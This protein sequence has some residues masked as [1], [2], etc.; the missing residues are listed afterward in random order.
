MAEEESEQP[1]EEIQLVVFKLGEEEYG[2]EI[3]D[4][5][6]IIKTGEITPVP[7]APVFVEGIINLRGKIVVV[8]DLL[9]R[10]G[11]FDETK[12]K[13]TH[14]IISEVEDSSFGILVDDVSEVLRIA[15]EDIKKAPGII[16]SK[17]HADYLRGVGVVGE[18]LL[19]LLDLMKVLSE[20]ELVEMADLTKGM[21][22]KGE[23][24][25]KE[26]EE[27]K[28]TISDEEIKRRF[29]EKFK[30][31]EKAPAE[32]EKPKKARAKK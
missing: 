1:K 21:K 23:E 13:G 16:A 12:H 22:I 31:K 9:K 26:E 19:I 11:A 29:E 7:N 8:I 32:E 30:K 4:V 2:V 20:K 25:E 24:Q 14:I 6:E 3:H 17:I 15:K 10:F 28:P 27:P 5:R 18:R